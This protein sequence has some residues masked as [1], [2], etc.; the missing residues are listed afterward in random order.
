[1]RKWAV[2]GVAFLVAL[3]A[4]AGIISGL[5]GRLAGY[6]RERV[7]STLK[8]E[9]GGN[10]EVKNLQVSIFP[11]IQI[12]AEGLV[13]RRGDRPDLPPLIRIKKARTDVEIGEF[14]RPRHHIHQVTVEGLVISLPPSQE[15]AQGNPVPRAKSKNPKPYKV[16]VDTIV[17]D[18]SELDILVTDPHKSPRVFHIYRLTIHNAGL[19]KQMSYRATLEN[20]IPVGQIQAHGT[21]GP[22]QRDNPRLTPLTG[23][24]TFSNAD[25]ASFRGLSGTLFSQGQF[26]GPLDRIEVQGE[27][28]TANFS[29]GISGHPVP[30]DTRFH[31]IVDG[32][33]GDTTLEHVDATLLS[34]KI[35]AHGGVVRVPGQQYRR[36]LL[37]A[38]SHDAKLQDFLRL[39]LKAN[40]PPMTGIMSFRT[41]LD[42]PPGKGVVVERLQLDGNFVISSGRFSK[43]NVEEKL[44]KLSRRAQGPDGAES[45][46]SVVSDFAGKFKLAERPNDFFGSDFQRAWGFCS[47]GR[48]LRPPRRG[49]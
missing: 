16:V 2:G 3:V 4:G 13:L 20:P 39:A 18:N 10:V 28:H 23:K 48:N 15:R 22:W 40:Q 11:R 12:A 45:Q 37:D 27:T 35:E 5:R 14:L 31:A 17:A 29:L 25:L 47:P 7:I 33:N 34:S 8:Q 38:T 9:Y 21:L 46:G 43:T 24:Y 42:I 1:M 41:R 26:N 49:H 6:V 32:S 19:G 30:L 44:T 36:V